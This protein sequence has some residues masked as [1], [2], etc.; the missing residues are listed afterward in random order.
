MREIARCPARHP[1][2]RGQCGKAAG[3]D[4]DHTLIVESQFLRC[5]AAPM[6]WW[7]S[8]PSGHDGPCAARP[9]LPNVGFYGDGLG[10]DTHPEG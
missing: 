5:P 9:I 6:G 7:C 4:G 8:R 2:T 10:T 1:G 3:H